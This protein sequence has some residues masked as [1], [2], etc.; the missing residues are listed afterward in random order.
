[1]DVEIS[2]C[3]TGFA[4]FLSHVPRPLEKQAN[5][6]QQADEALFPTILRVPHMFLRKDQGARP[7][8]PGYVGHK[9]Q[10]HTF[11]TYNFAPTYITLFAMLKS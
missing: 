10:S 7:P 1:M 6:K 4:P 2:S 3:F 5:H 8:Q 9:K 11:Y